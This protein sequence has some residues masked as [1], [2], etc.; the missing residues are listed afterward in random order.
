MGIKYRVI[1][2]NVKYPR[3]EISPLGDVKVIVPPNV[4]PEDL[5]GRKK[6]W[7]E[8]K[9][10]E[11]EEAR[12]KFLP[13]S[14]KLLL[15]GEFYEL[16]ESEEFGVNPKFHVVLLPKDDLETLKRWLKTQLREELEFKV[17]LFSSV[18]GVKY[19][20]IYI[21]FQ[22]T[23][24]A[25]CSEKGNLSFNLMLMALPEELRDYIIIHEVAHLKFQKHSRKFWEL[26]RQY[27]PDYKHAQKGLR[28]YW[29]ALQYNKIWNKLREIA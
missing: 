10:R 2:R 22:K 12:M 21:R 4:N 8:K 5:V 6:G 20:K 16:I 27:Y 14:N 26:V 19:R 28:E 7:I 11:I 17:R 3:I 15:D 13:L 18:F 23:K 9:L 29:L 24:W 25:S 1:R